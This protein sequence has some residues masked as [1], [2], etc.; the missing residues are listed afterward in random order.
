MENDLPAWTRVETG[1]EG[2]QEQEKRKRKDKKNKVSPVVS[3]LV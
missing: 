1:F 2:R 3:E